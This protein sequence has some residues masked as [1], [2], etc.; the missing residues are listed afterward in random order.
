[1]T[2]VANVN[3]PSAARQAADSAA[4]TESGGYAGHTDV[5]HVGTGNR[6]VA[7]A[8][9]AGLARRL[10]TNRYVISATV[11]DGC[12]ERKWPVGRSPLFCRVTVPVRPLTL[13]PTV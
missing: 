13:P 7:I 1:M 10:P 3:G 8:D 2:D 11:D 9:A 6:A 12:C 4:D 5:G